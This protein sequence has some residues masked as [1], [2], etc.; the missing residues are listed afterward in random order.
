MRFVRRILTWA[1]LAVWGNV[2]WWASQG[3]L[4]VAGAVALAVGGFAF[5]CYVNVRPTLRRM[6]AP[7]Q[8]L[9]TLVNGYELLLAGGVCLLADVAWWVWL[10]TSGALAG[11]DAPWLAFAGNVVVGVVTSAVLALG[12]FV[13][14]CIRSAQVS[15]ITKVL[16]V[17]LWWLPPLTAVLL[18]RVARTAM[19]EYRTALAR[20]RRDQAR[21]G[22]QVCRTRYPL[23]LVHGIFFRDWSALNYWGR[24]PDAL[25]RNGATIFYGGQ[26]SS[27]SVADSG[28]ELAAAIERVTA[29]TGCGKVNIVAHSKGGLDARWAISQLGCAEKVASL[30]TINT[31]H[32]GCNFARQLMERIPQTAVAA[33]GSRYDAVFTK[34]GDADPSFLAGVADLTD[35][36]CARLNEQLPDAPGVLYQ[37]V[38]S[39]MASRFASPF[40]L[41]LGNTLIEPLDGPNDGLVAVSSMPWGDFLGVVEPTKNQGISHGDMVDLM[42]K[43]IGDFDVC[44]FYVQLVAG[45]KARGL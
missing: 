37:S 45:L 35:T 39:R 31:P 7:E 17:L 14:L 10:L 32:R 26:Q 22:D 5:Y 16:V 29:A 15:L 28:T 24:I 33:I 11:P 6:V 20:I 25:T 43:D 19:R 1:V 41:N 9:V 38:G 30:T 13:R 27:A 12:G 40:P 42:R 36:E 23:L 4:P 21:A 8:G 34:L 2:V 18:S 44:E 3:P